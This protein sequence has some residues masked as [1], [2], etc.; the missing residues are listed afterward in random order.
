MSQIDVT[1]DQ[2]MLH[3]Y[4]TMLHH[5]IILSYIILYYIGQNLKSVAEGENK[6]WEEGLV[7]GAVYGGEKKHTELLNQVYGM[8]S[9]S[10]PLH[11]DLWP[12]VNQCEAE[13]ISMTAGL[14]NGGD[15]DVVGAMTSGGT[16]SIIMAVRAHLKLYGENR[17][18]VFPT[19][20]SGDTAHAGLNKACEMFGI[21]LLQVPCGESNGYQLDPKQ[22]EGFMNSNVIM[23]YASAPSY[24]QGVIDPIEELST[25][26]K[27][28]DVGLH[29]DACLGG[30]VLPFARMLDYDLP[31]FDFECP[32]VTS[33]SADTHKYGY[34]SKGTSVVLYRNKVS[35]KLVI[36]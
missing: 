15:E 32:G 33:M 16:E 23:I 9:L 10:N 27:K 18:I 35:R 24:P 2:F 34:A 21:R 31:K 12:K 17:G 28:F 26:A 4:H 20:I 5:S 19:I 36:E 7:S 8:Y 6:K 22:V 14:L 29:V 3:A 11:P 1:T 13:V 25:V 30:F